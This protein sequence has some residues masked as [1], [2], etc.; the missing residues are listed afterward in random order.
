MT[1][2][3]CVLCLNDTAKVSDEV[4]RKCPTRN[5][6]AQLSTLYTDPERHNTQRYRQTTVCDV[7]AVYFRV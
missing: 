2:P 3:W 1:I 4:N 5:T 7:R 6:T